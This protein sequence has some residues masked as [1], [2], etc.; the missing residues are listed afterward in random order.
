M[1]N[2]IQ[3]DLNK[4]IL[5]LKNELKRL[6]YKYIVTNQSIDKEFRCMYIHKLNKLNKNSCKIRVKNRCVLTGRA[7]SVYRLF[8]L[9]RIKFRELASQGMLPGVTKASW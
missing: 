1:S 3:K 6:Q 5:V 9:S 7:R 8:R 2:F 4:R